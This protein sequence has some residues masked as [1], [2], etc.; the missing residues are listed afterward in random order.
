MEDDIQPEPL[1][2]H[3]YA[4]TF[5]DQRPAIGE[6]K[7]RYYWNTPISVR[8]G[9]RVRIRLKRRNSRIIAKQETYY[10]PAESRSPQT[11]PRYIAGLI[12]QN[13]DNKTV[14]SNSPIRVIAGTREEVFDTHNH[15]TGYTYSVSFV[16]AADWIN[17]YSNIN[18]V[19]PA[20]SHTRS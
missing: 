13:F 11:L 18:L 17:I 1:L 6:I 2:P 15:V 19:S 5:V 14:V 20:P 10:I 3:V 7:P 4:E 8:D 16:E 9:E 12:N